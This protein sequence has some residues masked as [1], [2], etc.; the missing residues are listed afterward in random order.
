SGQEAFTL[1]GHAQPVF[2]VTFSPDGRR[3]ASAGRDAVVKVWDL[4]SGEPAPGSRVLSPQYTVPQLSA[5]AW[6]LAFS[7]D[8]Q[9]LAVAG[10]ESDDMVGIYEV[11][12]GKLLL[13]L[14]DYIRIVGVAFNADGQRLA[15]AGLDKT[16]RLWDTKTGHE[17]LTLGGHTDL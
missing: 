5:G 16:V 3:L 4:P 17:I 7:P 11:A 13:A 10:M 14:R 12:T 15:S 9:R 2:N 8:G 6:C 1:V